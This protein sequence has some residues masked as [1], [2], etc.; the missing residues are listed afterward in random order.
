MVEA[1]GPDTPA[2]N[3]TR[4]PKNGGVSDGGRVRTCHRLGHPAS[5]N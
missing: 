4:P 5:G 2:G 3:S 1:G